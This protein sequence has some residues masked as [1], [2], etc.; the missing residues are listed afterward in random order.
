MDFYFILLKLAK[1]SSN[2]GK[3]LFEGLIHLFIYIRNNTNLG[4]IY[5]DKIEDKPLSDLLKQSII[6]T[7]NQLMVLY[8]SI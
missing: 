2:T 4:L 1:F 7:D 6:I 3:I 8:D 5:S